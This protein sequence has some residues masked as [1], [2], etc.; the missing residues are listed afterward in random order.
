ML[1]KLFVI[2]KS[3]SSGTL[4]I[5]ALSC[6]FFLSSFSSFAQPSIEW[7]K[8]IGGST[9]DFAYSIQQTTDGGYVIAGS[10]YSAP[11][12]HGLQDYWVVKI[13]PIGFIEW[14]KCLG[15][16]GYDEATS[17]QQT[18]DG[19]YVVAG[20]SLSNNGDVTGNHGGSDYWITKLDSAGT[21]IWQKCFGGTGEDKAYSVQQTIDGGYIVAGYSFSN[22]GDVSGNHGVQDYWIIKINSVGTLIWQKCLGGTGEDKA[23]SIQQTT[24]EGYIVAG[25][26]CSNDGD[27]SGNHNILK[28]FWIIKINSVGTL[29]WQ[30]CLGGTGSDYA[31]FVKETVDGG[32][33]VA[34]TT[35][36]NNFNVSGNHGSSDCWI[37]KVDSVGSLIWQKCLGGTAQDE[38]TSIQQTTDGGYII[39]GWSN[40]NNGD[41]SDNHGS[42]DYWI[43]KLN[44]AGT[45]VWQKSLGGSLEDK[46]TSIQQTTDGGYIVAGYTNSNNGDIS[47]NHGLRDYWVLKLSCSDYTYS[48]T[49]LDTSW[50]YS[51]THEFIDT[52]VLVSADTIV[53]MIIT[54]TDS[55]FVDN[56]TIWSIYQSDS[57]IITVY[58]CDSAVVDYSF[59]ISD[60]VCSYYFDTII[61]QHSDTVYLTATEK[62]NYLGIKIYPNPVFDFLYIETAGREFEFELFDITGQLIMFG[63]K[64]KINMSGLPAGIYILKIITDYGETF[65]QKVIKR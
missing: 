60:T 63:K 2:P 65:R 9:P 56:V 27:V 40:S 42:Y 61:Y 46:A 31:Y 48:E 22:D 19:G 62:I 34:G 23:Y 54:T 3:L 33:I 17:I 32:Y 50:V 7:Q 26:T 28:D 24:D 38:A 6:L 43:I 5:V 11:G 41:V 36:S 13:N 44:S 4:K 52:I 30:K 16:T 47:G 12:S 18:T 1:K 51:V 15:G 64:E 8:C 49:I 45:L 10:T 58:H 53:N 37:T 55:M 25:Y 14:Q 21:L 35:N 39:A 20:Y 59:F 57:N 29:I